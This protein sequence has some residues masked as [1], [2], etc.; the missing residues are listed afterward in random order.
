MLG[1][2][3]IKNEHFIKAYIYRTHTQDEQDQEGKAFEEST[4]DSH[5]IQPL[6]DG[7]SPSFLFCSFKS[8]NR[9]LTFCRINSRAS[10]NSV[11]PESQF[12]SLAF[13]F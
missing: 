8:K 5:F 9:R 10:V 12:P 6:K 3:D 7:R 2:P 11:H 1:S 13:V 4:Q